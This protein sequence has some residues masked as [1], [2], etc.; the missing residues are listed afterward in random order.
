MISARRFLE[1]LLILAGVWL[2]FRQ[3]PDYAATLYVAFGNEDFASSVDR[4]RSP[5]LIMQGIYLAANVACGLLLIACRS[6]LARTL[7]PN[8]LSG[9]SLESTSLIAAGTA[10]IGTYFIISGVVELGAHFMLTRDLR[11]EPFVRWRGVFSL[12][13]GLVLF[14]VSAW[15][16]RIWETL[17]RRLH[18]GA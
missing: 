1:A 17:K 11:S 8:E 16:A 10:L 18:H 4:G 3:L 15:S 13:A 6:L 14:L 5:L 2:L 12:L 9:V 7:F